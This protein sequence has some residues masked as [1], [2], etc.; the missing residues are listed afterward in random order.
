MSGGNDV[1]WLLKQPLYRIVQYNY[2]FKKLLQC[3]A[4]PSSLEHLALLNL[5]NLIREMTFIIEQG[6]EESHKRRQQAFGENSPVIYRNITNTHQQYEGWNILFIGDESD[7]SKTRLQQAFGQSL[8]ERPFIAESAQFR[9]YMISVILDP[10]LALVSQEVVMRL[11]DTTGL[12]TFKRMLILQYPLTDLYLLCFTIDSKQSF[13]NIIPAVSNYNKRKSKF[14]IH[15]FVVVYR[16]KSLFREY[17][18]FS[19]RN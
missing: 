15:L 17:S 9:N 19:G 16:N 7:R 11:W 2:L 4:S 14:L 18:F 3:T 13:K 10:P 6:L 12:E 5:I 8:E 1:A